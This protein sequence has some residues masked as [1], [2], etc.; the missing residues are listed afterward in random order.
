VTAPIFQPPDQPAR[1][2]AKR[3]RAQPGTWTGE[4]AHCGGQNL[5][6]AGRDIGLHHPRRI[7]GRRLG[8]P[9]ERVATEQ[10]WCPGSLHPAVAGTVEKTPDTGHPHPSRLMRSDVRARIQQRDGA[11]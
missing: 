5:P 2:S 6:M 4:C 7:K 10:G 3:D 8:M 9:L 11:A 1:A